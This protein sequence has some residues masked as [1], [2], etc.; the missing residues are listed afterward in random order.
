M[1]HELNFIITLNIKTNKLQY[2]YRKGMIMGHELNFINTLNIKT[3]YSM[4]IPISIF[5]WH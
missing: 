2:A 1:R 3:N 4:L 5:I